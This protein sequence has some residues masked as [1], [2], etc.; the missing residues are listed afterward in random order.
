MVLMTT[1][2]LACSAIG[3]NEADPFSAVSVWV[4]SLELTRIHRK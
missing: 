4:N 3:V 2:M 1:F